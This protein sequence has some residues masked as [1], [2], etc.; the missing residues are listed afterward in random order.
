MRGLKSAWLVTLAF[1]IGAAHA[2]LLPNN[3]DS[4]R[5]PYG[6]IFE[7]VVDA[8]SQIESL[9][10]TN[11][12]PLRPELKGRKS[13]DIPDAFIDAV[14]EKVVKE[15]KSSSSQSART[16]F[17]YYFF[18]PAVPTVAIGQQSPR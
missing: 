14:R 7:V 17:T 12:V 2:Q 9:K 18:D 1:W 5:P 3:T 16:F 13:V 4:A 8:K 10:I 6:V 15:L 11:V